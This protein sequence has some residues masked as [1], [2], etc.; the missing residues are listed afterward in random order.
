MWFRSRNIGPVGPR[1]GPWDLGESL[2]VQ[3]DGAP[4]DLRELRS[5]LI[6]QYLGS[7]TFSA[8]VYVGSRIKA[9]MVK[10]VRKSM[11]IPKGDI[12]KVVVDGT[13]FG[14]AKNGSVISSDG[15][16]WKE[17]WGNSQ[18]TNWKALSLAQ[19]AQRLSFKPSGI[20]ID[21]AVIKMTFGFY[22]A[23]DL[24]R[25]IGGVLHTFHSA[26]AEH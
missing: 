7:K 8:G 18:F 21:N 22:A 1:P 15:M 4:L 16:Y 24:E 25:I 23:Q 6:E 17:F 10:T 5:W 12:V 13:T 9:S 26:F 19:G 11:N 20:F 2:L 3:E 14:S